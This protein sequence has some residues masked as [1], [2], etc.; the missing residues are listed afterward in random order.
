MATIINH[1]RPDTCPC[2]FDY[3]WDSESDPNTRVHTLASAT[4]CQYHSGIS[5]PDALYIHVG[6]EN[7]SKNRAEAALAT[8]FG[9]GVA[10]NLTY[11][12]ATGTGTNRPLQIHVP[13]AVASQVATVLATH[14]AVT[15]VINPSAL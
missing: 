13:S 8:A 3:S 12:S 14:T 4:V 9:T 11:G 15:L 10:I 6:I 2:E 7:T 5:T 1:W